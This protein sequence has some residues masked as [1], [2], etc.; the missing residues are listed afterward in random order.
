[1]QSV[2]NDTLGKPHVILVMITS[3]YTAYHV[4]PVC[5]SRYRKNVVDGISKL[6]IC[7]SMYE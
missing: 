5:I 4:I 1:M 6:F 3:A 2:Y 7:S